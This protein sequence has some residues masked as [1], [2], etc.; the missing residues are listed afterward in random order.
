MSEKSLSLNNFFTITFSSN[1]S[2]LALFA[3]F[4]N[5]LSQ[6]YL[7]SGSYSWLSNFDIKSNLFLTLTFLTSISLINLELFS[8]SFSRESILSFIESI[9]ILES[10]L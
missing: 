5:S 4:T 9:S 1:N 3:A 2:S 10:L 7:Q 8:F 6:Q